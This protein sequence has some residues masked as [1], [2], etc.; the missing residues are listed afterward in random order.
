MDAGTAIEK[1]VMR[2]ISGDHATP[3]VGYDVLPLRRDNS[4]IVNSIE[5]KLV[6]G[7]VF[8]DG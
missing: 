3:V 4:S 8:S 7:G 2:H 1:I 5:G 6:S